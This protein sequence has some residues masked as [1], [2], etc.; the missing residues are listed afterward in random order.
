MIY[1]LANDTRHHMGSKSMMMMMGLVCC[2]CCVLL[3]SGGAGGAYALRDDLGLTD[4]FDGMGLTTTTTTSDDDDGDGQATASPSS[5]ADA[6]RDAELAKTS[7]YSLV[8]SSGTETDFEFGETSGAGYAFTAMGDKGNA[9]GSSSAKGIYTKYNSL[10]RAR[11][12][13]EVYVNQTKNTSKITLQRNPADESRKTFMVFFG[14]HKHLASGDGTGKGR[15]ECKYAET[16]TMGHADNSVTARFLWSL[17]KDTQYANT[18]RLWN[19]HCNKELLVLSHND[20]KLVELGYGTRFVI[21]A[22]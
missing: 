21:S 18:Y 7:S 8:D 13:D 19:K 11:N 3:C 5:M 17:V 6:S 10:G 12:K 9:G 22:M 1:Y 2:C 20:A 14:E 4:L 15:N 16:Y